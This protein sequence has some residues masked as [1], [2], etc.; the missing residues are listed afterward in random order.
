MYDPHRL[1]LIRFFF[2][3]ALTDLVKQ[4]FSTIHVSTVGPL[5]TPT[6]ALT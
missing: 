6:S 4:M 2:L 3:Q 1:K 5:Q